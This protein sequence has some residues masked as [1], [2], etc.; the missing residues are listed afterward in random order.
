LKMQL[1]TSSPS[2]NEI[3]LLKMSQLL[4]SFHNNLPEL[5]NS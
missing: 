1:T 5:S 3:Y 4:T 2:R